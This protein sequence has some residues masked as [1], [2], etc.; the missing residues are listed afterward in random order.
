MKTAI[1]GL[2]LAVNAFAYPEIGDRAELTGDTLTRNGE[3]T[4][5]EINTELLGYDQSSQQW[6]VGIQELRSGERRSRTEKQAALFTPKLYQEMMK[7]C[8]QR[9]GRVEKITVAAGTFDVCHMLTAVTLDLTEET[10]Y[11]NVPFGVVKKIETN[12]TEGRKDS[13]E[14]KSFRPGLQS[15]H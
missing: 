6:E 8:R 7:N 1:F 13:L 3:I 14:L 5:L 15:Q 10:W 12:Y 2:L 11:G 4:P 9:G